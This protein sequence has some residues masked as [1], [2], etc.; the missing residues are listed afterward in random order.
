MLLL[1]GS[2]RSGGTEGQVALLAN[3]LA[4]RGVRVT[5][6][7]LNGEH[8]HF[9]LS[10]EVTLEV[11][12]TGGVRSLLPACVR[13]RRLARG[14]DCVMSFLDVCNVL[15]AAVVRSCPVVFNVR[16]SG[17]SPGWVAYSAFRVAR[18]L[19]VRALR[20]V[21]NSRQVQR[22]YQQRGFHPGSWLVIPN[23]VDLCRFRP[24]R[25]MRMRVRASLGVGEDAPLVGFF[26]RYQEEKRFDVFVEAMASRCPDAHLV[27]VG[28]GSDAD[29]PDLRTILGSL[30]ERAHLLGERQDVPE[31]LAAMDVVVNASD[32]EGFSNALLES[33]ACGVPCVATN[34]PANVEVLDAAGV[35]VPAGNAA[36]LGEAVRALLQDEDRRGELRRRGIERA[37]SHFELERWC[38][39]FEATIADCG[40]AP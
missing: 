22:F 1:V 24:D 13:L 21:S 11:L 19:S 40:H 28:R 35:T 15:A 25:E 34:I 18:S 2:L 29:N 37:R 7:I 36:M 33:M 30:Y 6:T 32:F 20:I 26:A 27:F 8:Q 17:V 14:H 23:G 9:R 39:A 12:G 3:R 5:L 16:S 31:L 4:A 38:D 10:P